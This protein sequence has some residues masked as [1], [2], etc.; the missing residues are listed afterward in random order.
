M[1]E[2]EPIELEIRGKDRAVRITWDDDHTSLYPMRYLRGYCPCAQCQGHSGRWEFVAVEA[3]EVVRV[4]EVGAYALRIVW[5][6]GNE[7]QHTTGIYSF[8]NLREL[9]PCDTCRTAAG[10]RHPF[11]RMA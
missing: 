3:P 6:D 2:A 10:P 5:N 8:E 1:M 11:H 9:C 4:E 7:R